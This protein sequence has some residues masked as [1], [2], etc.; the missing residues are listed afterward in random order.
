MTASAHQQHIQIAGVLRGTFNHHEPAHILY[1]RLFTKL[2]DP[3]LHPLYVIAENKER[4]VWNLFQHFPDRTYIICLGT[5]SAKHLAGGQIIPPPHM[6]CHCLRALDLLQISFHSTFRF[7]RYFFP[8]LI[9]KDKSISHLC[10][11]VFK[12]FFA[13]KVAG[14]ISRIPRQHLPVKI[15]ISFMIFKGF[16]PKQLPPDSMGEL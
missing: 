12:I 2:W 13:L 4:R 9:R 11:D 8:Y 16:S 3:F 6:E 15:T 7:R 5:D 1:L 14:Q 10:F